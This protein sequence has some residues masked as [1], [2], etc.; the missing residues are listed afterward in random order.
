MSNLLKCIILLKI[1]LEA[2]NSSC[3]KSVSPFR[4]APPPVKVTPFSIIS[5]DN[6]G[7]VFSKTCFIA[8]IIFSMLFFRANS[9]SSLVTVMVLGNPPTKSLPFTLSFSFS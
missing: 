4:R 2:F 9:I 1:N 3:N 8:I 6:S 7:G 5:A